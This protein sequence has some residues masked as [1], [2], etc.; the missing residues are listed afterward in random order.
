M[1]HVGLAA[2]NGA[3]VRLSSL[4]IKEEFFASMKPTLAFVLSSAS[5]D[6]V[7]SMRPDPYRCWPSISLGQTRMNVL[8]ANISGF[9]LAVEGLLAHYELLRGPGSPPYH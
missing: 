2:L 1:L 6:V 3:A 9:R 5:S 8:H 4:A 7:I